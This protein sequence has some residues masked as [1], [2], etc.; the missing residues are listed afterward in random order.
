MQTRSDNRSGPNQPNGRDVLGINDI[1]RVGGD[2]R[3]A[4]AVTNMASDPTAFG[5]P[6]DLVAGAV[7]K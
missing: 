5:P 2:S 1:C 3:V 7:I 4:L 6:K